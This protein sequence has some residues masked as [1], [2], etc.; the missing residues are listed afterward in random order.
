MV[1]LVLALL[2]FDLVPSSFICIGFIYFFIGIASNSSLP[3][4]IPTISN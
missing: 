1:A 3:D 2:P 4:A